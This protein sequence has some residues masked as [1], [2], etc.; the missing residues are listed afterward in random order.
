MRK[1]CAQ[2]SPSFPALPRKMHSQNEK[3]R[4]QGAAGNQPCHGLRDISDELAWELMQQG[5]EESH[6]EAVCFTSTLKEP[7][8][9]LSACSVARPRLIQASPR[10][11]QSSVTADTRAGLQEEA[12]ALSLLHPRWPP[13][14]HPCCLLASVRSQGLGCSTINP[15]SSGYLGGL[16]TRA[17]SLFKLHTTGLDLS[18]VSSFCNALPSEGWSNSLCYLRWTNVFV[19]DKE[20]KHCVPHQW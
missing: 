16:I 14:A 12:G 3:Q 6:R 9:D 4:W 17:W 18:H 1:S 7:L 10:P 11:P 15:I 19:P 2:R 20:N 5:G 13:H 8:T